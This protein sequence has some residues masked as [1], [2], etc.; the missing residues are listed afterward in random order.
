MHAA[1]NRSGASKHGSNSIQRSC[2]SPNS[3]HKDTQQLPTSHPVRSLSATVDCCAASPNHS[4]RTRRYHDRKCFRKVAGVCESVRRKYGEVWARSEISMLALESQGEADRCSAHL[5]QQKDVRTRSDDVPGR[6]LDWTF[7]IRSSPAA[8]VTSASAIHLKRVFST[9][10][11]PFGLA[12]SDSCSPLRHS[13]W[14]PPL[15]RPLGRLR[16]HAA[17]LQEARFGSR[18][19]RDHSQQRKR[20]RSPKRVDSPQE[21]P[22]PTQTEAGGS[23]NRALCQR[24]HGAARDAS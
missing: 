11:A 7:E 1:C 21:H 4:S 6:T 2:L 22:R 12:T 3:T 23:N 8:V 15:T 20:H 5:K 24:T 16:E 9:V 19:R 18:S 14:R 10:S 17:G 13:H